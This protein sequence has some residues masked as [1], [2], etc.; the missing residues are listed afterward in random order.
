MFG[1]KD[2]FKYEVEVK[3]LIREA[4]EGLN[5][6][7]SVLETQNQQLIQELNQLKNGLCNDF[8]RLEKRITDFTDVWHPFMIQ[9]INR[10]K[11]DLEKTIIEAER[12]DIKKV[13]VD[14]ESKLK[15]ISEERSIGLMDNILV[16][17]QNNLQIFVH[18]DSNN[19]EIW[20]K[21]NTI[22]GLFV[23][24]QGGNDPF[25]HSLFILESLKCL[26][27]AY[28]DPQSCFGWIKTI[29]KKR[30]ILYE[31]NGH[32]PSLTSDYIIQNQQVKNIYK[33]CKELDVKF[34]F[35]GEDRIN[36][37]PLKMIFEDE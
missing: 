4:T 27:N 18:K 14:L 34:K 24:N 19:E 22:S 5:H 20:K 25:Q 21:F 9:N 6:R 32:M 26:K 8:Q 37:I 7:V 12:E 29:N 28:Y 16:G 3:A 10:I 17:Y 33:L 30:E 1:K 31:C 35:G 2:G 36:G 11:E 15:Q 13:H 23:C